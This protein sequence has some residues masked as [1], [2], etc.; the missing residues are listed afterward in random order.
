MKQQTYPVFLRNYYLCSALEDLVFAYAI[1]NVMFHM[2][3]LSFL[4]ISILLAWWAAVAMIAEVPSGALADYWNHKKLLVIAPLVK[5]LCFITWYFAEGSFYVYA[6]GFLFWGVSES[7]LSGTTEALLYDHLVFF[8][9][10][11]DY[12]RVLGRKKFYYYLALMSATIIGG[13]IA[14]YQMTLTLLLSI[15]PL[16]LSAFFA[17]RIREVPKA[18]FTAENADDPTGEFRYI[19]YFKIAFQEIRTNRVLRYILIYAL[20][21]SIFGDLEEFDQLY[22]ELVNLPIWAFG[23]VASIGAL[24]N[25]LSSRLGHRFKDKPGV[26][27]LL[28]ALSA[29]CLW[30]AG[31]FP[32]VPAIALL[33]LSYVCVE[34]LMILVESRLQHSIRSVSRATIT[35]VNTFLICLVGILITPVYGLISKIWNFQSIYVYSSVYLALLTAWVFKNRYILLAPLQH[36]EDNKGKNL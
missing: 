19:D 18:D 25:A 33:L 31:R 2:Q 34:P 36:I 10:R 1:Y 15:I 4:H 26:H 24:L 3:G 17:S 28:L 5:S 16:L 22:Y 29:A 6:L 7:F 13:I 20:G 12:E 9:K 32:A 21:I 27:Y 35:S 23:V 14:H 8:D 30:V 11:D